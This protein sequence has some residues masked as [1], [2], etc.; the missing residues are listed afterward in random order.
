M[1]PTEQ[2]LKEKSTRRSSSSTSNEDLETFLQIVASVIDE[3]IADIKNSNQQA[4]DRHQD[5]AAIVNGDPREE[6]KNHHRANDDGEIDVY[7]VIQPHPEV[8][9]LI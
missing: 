8:I 1:R 2:P 5:A 3:A 7:Q 6:S 4:L 9:D